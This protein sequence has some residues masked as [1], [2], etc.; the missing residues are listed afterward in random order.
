M[1]AIVPAPDPA[2]SAA[3]GQPAVPEGERAARES[4]ESTEA[5][6]DDA[7]APP[8]VAS[9]LAENDLCGLLARQAELKAASAAGLL[10]L[11]ESGGG[12][13][14]EDDLALRILRSASGGRAARALK[15]LKGYRDPDADF[16]RALLLARLFESTSA[17]PKDDAGGKIP[18]LRGASALLQKLSRGDRE[19][20]AA[21]FFRAAV[22]GL[23]PNCFPKG[24]KIFVNWSISRLVVYSL[25]FLKGYILANLNPVCIFNRGCR[26]VV[27]EIPIVYRFHLWA[28]KIR[29]NRFCGTF[30]W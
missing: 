23:A 26:Q 13:T 28:I 5:G 25:Q 20:A 29:E 12:G 21:P 18:D 6:P 22:L 15:E 14:A 8:P 2:K 9:L 30:D 27:C 1:A 17:Y 19:N 4:Q 7:E 10:A 3:P 11:L 24:I 16:L